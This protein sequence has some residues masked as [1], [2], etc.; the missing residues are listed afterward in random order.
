MRRNETLRRNSEAIIRRFTQITAATIW[1]PV[2]EVTFNFPTGHPQ[3]LVKIQDSFYVSSV[4]LTSPPKKLSPPQHGYDRTPGEGIGY[5]FHV[6]SDGNL[7]KKVSPGEGTI[8]HPGGIDYDGESIW[9]PVAEYRPNSRS[10]IYRICPETFEVNEVFRCS[11]H[12]GGLAYNRWN[13]TLHGITWGGRTFYDWTPGGSQ[14]A[15]CV[16]RSHYIDYQDCQFLE[17]RYMLCSG[18]S[19]YSL[20][21]TGHTRLGGIDL[22]DLELHAAI[23][24]IPVPL[25]SRRKRPMTQN[26]F[27]VELHGECL[28]F[29]FLPDDSE[30]TLYVYDVHV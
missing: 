20:P 19:S 12:I 14:I 10:I 28:R 11:D 4:D 27:S 26:P 22:I 13:D 1:Q 6:D 29:Y 17:P 9:V 23:H 21:G 5:L 25:Y 18:L 3:G 16:N 7:L 2:T 15:A 24:Q 8:Y 30:S